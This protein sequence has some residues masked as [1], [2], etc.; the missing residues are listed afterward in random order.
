MV[1]PELFEA[2]AT[3]AGIGG[4]GR[5]AARL[6]AVEGLTPAEA[7]SR[8]GLGCRSSATRPYNR[9][10]DALALVRPYLRPELTTGDDERMMASFPVAGDEPVGAG[11]QQPFPASRG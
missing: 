5:E 9:F 2:L 7:A 8:L 3:V 1:A 4:Q 11:I 6:V 10:A